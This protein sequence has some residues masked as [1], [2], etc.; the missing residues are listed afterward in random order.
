M[1]EHTASTTKT[2]SL[3]Q[4]LERVKCATTASVTFY[5]A[6]H[7]S[8]P[9]QARSSPPDSTPS[10]LFR[11]VYNKKHDKD[12]ELLQTSLSNDSNQLEE[13]LPLKNGFVQTILE[14]Y[15]HH[16][17][18]IIRPDDIWLAIL[19]QFN[20]FINGN[21]ETLRER[22]VSHEGKEKLVIE[23]IGNRYSIDFGGMSRR[24]TALME[25]K[26][27]DPKLRE[28]IM[29]KFSTTTETDTTIYAIIMMCAMKNWFDYVFRLRCGIPQVTLEGTREDWVN[30]LLRIEKLKEYGK[31]AANWYKLLRPVVSRFVAAYD[32]PH[33]PS[34]LD[35]WNKVAHIESQGSGP[36]YLKGWI[37]AFCVFNHKGSHIRSASYWGTQKS[38]MLDHV[39]YPRIDITDI[40]LGHGEVDVELDDNGERFDTVMV[41][42]QIGLKMCRNSRG[43]SLGKDTVRPVAGWWYLIATPKTNLT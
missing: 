25:Q 37:T 33:S 23:D 29:P 21:A 1:N 5:P 24:M 22:F 39:E 18:L 12:F 14:A 19:V 41:A 26:I 38:L 16:R 43:G 31:D 40:P 3:D 11:R 4:Q 8:E 27:V 35:F 2:S 32:D 17:A 7:P 34:N 42:G 28:W 6:S 13:I 10:A 20:F 15:N 30:I 9:F 36:T